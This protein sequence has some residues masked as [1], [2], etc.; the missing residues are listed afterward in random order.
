LTVF[1]LIAVVTLVAVAASVIGR[2]SSAPGDQAPI[3]SGFV[4]QA[5][6]G[7]TTMLG[8]QRPS[9]LPA[10]QAGV[11]AE[12]AQITTLTGDLRSWAAATDADGQTRDW[13][14]A[15][16]RFTSDEQR[17]GAA[18]ATQ[19]LPPPSAT[20]SS[21]AADPGAPGGRTVMAA[22]DPAALGRQATTEADAADHFAMVNGLGACTIL[23]QGPAS[24]ESIPS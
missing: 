15:W 13:L 7:C 24:M 9:A 19:P 17:R 6:R 4:T 21:P 10:D 1:A 22:P 16:Q 5:N 14:A 2:P 23:A 8:T 11:R 20:G 18:L 12:V 3:P